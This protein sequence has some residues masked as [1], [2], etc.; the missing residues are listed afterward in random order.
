MAHPSDKVLSKTK[1]ERDTVD[2]LA[3]D[4][5]GRMIRW[6]LEDSFS[7]AAPPDDLWPRIMLR[8]QEAHASARHTPAKRRPSFSLAPLVQAVVASALLLAFGLGVDRNVTAPRG[9]QAVRS[10]P[11]VPAAVPAQQ[12]ANDML[13]G[14]VLSRMA[15]EPPVPQRPGGARP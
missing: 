8:A 11:T 12:E 6:G 5:L 9:E 10:T 14:Y 3:D 1:D 4:E 15:Q 13:S 2:P 7:G